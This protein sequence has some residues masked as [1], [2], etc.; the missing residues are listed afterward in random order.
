M[1]E[2][3]KQYES[4]Y[5]DFIE[6]LNKHKVEFLVVGAY[7]VIFHTKIPRDT[8]DID[9]WIKDSDENAK[10]CAKAIKEFSGLDVNHKELI[11]KEEMYYMGIV[12]HR[13]DIFNEQ[14]GLNFEKSFKNK[15]TG[16]FRGE[17][18]FFVNIDDLLRIKKAK[19]REI[20]KKDIKRL[21]N[22]VKG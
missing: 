22:E 14:Y 2:K 15:V 3:E 4:D 19:G 18:V 11:K 13:I 9:F 1:T 20:D 17:N 6:L 7:A 8:Q 10:K 5:K 12:P 21:E 16:K